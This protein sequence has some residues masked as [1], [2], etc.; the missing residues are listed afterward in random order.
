VPLHVHDTVTKRQVAFTAHFMGY[1]LLR[2]DDG[3]ALLRQNHNEQELI[4][5]SS[6]ET[7]IDFLKH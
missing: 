1:Q 3:Y 2:C 5:A 4:E 6:L 7:T